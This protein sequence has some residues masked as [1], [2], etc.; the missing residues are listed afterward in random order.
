LRDVEQ[1]AQTQALVLDPFVVVAG[2]QVAAIAVESLGHPAIA[3]Q[4][5]ELVDV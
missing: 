1:R 2:Q 4:A 3:Q 5:L